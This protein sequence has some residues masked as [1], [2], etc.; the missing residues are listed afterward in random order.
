MGILDGE[1]NTEWI[2]VELY[3]LER[4]IFLVIRR[5]MVEIIFTILRL[6][7]IRHSAGRG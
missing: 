4:K 2:M 1:S 5:K 6:F 3:H 7:I